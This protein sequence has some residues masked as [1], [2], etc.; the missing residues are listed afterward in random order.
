MSFGAYAVL[1]YIADAGVNIY[2]WLEPGQMVQGL[3]LAESTPGP[4]IMVTQYVGFLGAWKF[5]E[6]MSPLLSGVLGA[7]TV[8]YVTFLP[9]FMFIFVLAP[10]VEGLAENRRLQASLAGITAAVVGVILNLAVFFGTHILF[11]SGGLD[12]LAL[13]LSIV[14][15]L[16]LRYLHW[17][18]HT[19]VGTGASI[20]VLWFL[21]RNGL[22]L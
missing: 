12:G 21:L 3:A 19:V 13:M 8:T 20:G 22:G 5:H 14:A 6:S 16:A 18:I 11:P 1:S 10:Y 7:L 17:Q 15:F 2:G 9:C 4:L